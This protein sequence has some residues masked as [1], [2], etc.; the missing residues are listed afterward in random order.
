VSNAPS[1][2]SSLQPQTDYGT[3]WSCV[4][5]LSMPSVTVKGNRIVAEAVARRLITR[6]GQLV[7]DPNYGFALT[8]YLEADLNAAD[9]ARIQTGVQAECLKDERVSGATATVTFAGSLL[10]VTIVFTT[11]TGPF[12]LVLSVNDVSATLLQ[13]AP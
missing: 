1:N 8:D 11:S 3:A 4:D 12:T 5:D 13:V 2:V 7:D 6:R 10:V 9:L